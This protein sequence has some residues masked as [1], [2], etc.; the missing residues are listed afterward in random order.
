MSS[1][2]PSINDL[3]PIVHAGVEKEPML[4]LDTSGSMS[5]PAAEG[6]SA[7]RL[8]VIGEAMGRIVEVLGAEDSQAEGRRRPARRPVV[9]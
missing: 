3:S 4:L 2:E 1:T 8:S 5:W 9:S 7:Q 6:S